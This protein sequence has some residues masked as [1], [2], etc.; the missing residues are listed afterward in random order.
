MAILQIDANDYWED[1]QYDDCAT[2]IKRE[3]QATCKHQ[4]EEVNAEPP[5]DVCVS[6]GEVRK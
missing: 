4:W 3:Q 2:L 5:Y 1:Q 6:C